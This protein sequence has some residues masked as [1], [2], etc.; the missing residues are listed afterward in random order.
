MI[1]KIPKARI[2]F[3][4]G[5]TEDSTVVLLFSDKDFIVVTQS[6]AY[7]PKWHFK[8]YDEWHY[9]L[10]Y[11]PE[12]SDATVGTRGTDFSFVDC[13]VG[14]EDAEQIELWFEPIKES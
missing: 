8:S 9:I 5:H 12:L 4:D 1:N 3:R 6:G 7:R 14:Y 2:K 11:L 13:W 10:K